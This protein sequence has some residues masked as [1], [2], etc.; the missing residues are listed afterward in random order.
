MTQKNTACTYFK[1]ESV[2]VSPIIPERW[3]NKLT[4][5]SDTGCPDS[6]KSVWPA[7]SLVWDMRE[8]SLTSP[9]GPQP[10]VSEAEKEFPVLRS[11]PARF[12]LFS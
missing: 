12:I 11:N 5:H 9:T 4:L 3:L 6:L 10:P 7:P 2:A 1:G 8:L